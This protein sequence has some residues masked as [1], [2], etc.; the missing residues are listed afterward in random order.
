MIETGPVSGGT[1]K[2]VVYPRTQ[3][4]EEA[5]EPPVATV[6][7][8]APPTEKGPIVLVQASGGVRVKMA[9]VT[10]R[11]TDIAPK[12]RAVRVG[13]IKHGRNK[14]ST[15]TATATQTV[16]GK[17]TVVPVPVEMDTGVDVQVGAVPIQ[18]VA[19]V[20]AAEVREEVLPTTTRENTIVSPIN[21]QNHSNAR[22][23]RSPNSNNQQW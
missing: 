23:A 9:T 21:R 6:D 16:I 12:K 8:P 7:T 1:E 14:A 3:A 5:V 11:K 20:A 2:G 19:E 13:D 22:L 10:V 17:G 18:R 15:A 4:E